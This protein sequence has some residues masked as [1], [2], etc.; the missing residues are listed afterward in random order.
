MR[1]FTRFALPFTF[2]VLLVAGCGKQDEGKPNPDLKVPDVP[3][4][5][6]SVGGRDAP[7]EKE[8]DVKK[9]T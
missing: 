4:G 8:K 7:K 5:G 2:A 9:K 1:R 3:P 6:N